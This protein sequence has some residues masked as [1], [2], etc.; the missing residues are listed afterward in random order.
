VVL[1][2]VVWCCV[3]L[4]GVVWCCVFGVLCVVCVT[5]IILFSLNNVTPR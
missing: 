3:V 4:C 1:C 5:H 2:G